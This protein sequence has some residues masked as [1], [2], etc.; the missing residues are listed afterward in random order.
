MIIDHYA[1]NLI[2][3]ASRVSAYPMWLLR[4]G[5]QDISSR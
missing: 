1:W 5:C 3:N 4:M 2:I